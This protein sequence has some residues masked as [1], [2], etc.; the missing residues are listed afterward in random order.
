[1]SDVLRPLAFGSLVGWALDEHARHGSVFGLPAHHVHHPRGRR[2]RDAFGH[3][4]A[5]PVGAAAG[6]HTQLAQNIV[7]AYLAGARV[8]ELKTVQ[9]LDGEVIR[10]AVPK[11]CIHAEDEGQNC[12][13]STELTVR[14]ALTEYVH[15][16]L[17]IRVL[18]VEL[19]LGDGDDVVFDASVGYELDG[20]RGP[21]VD[22]FLEG[23]RD[24][25]R[26]DA[27]HLATT[28][29]EA[30]LGR[31]EHFDGQH[32]AR[33]PTRVCDSV[34]ISTMHGCP[35]AEIERI[36]EHLLGKGLHTSVKCNPTL[37][38]YDTVR[39]T[40]DRLGYAHV[41]F[42]DSHFTADLQ[43]DEAV[44]MFTRLA[45][46]AEAS[47]LVF[48]LKL[49]NTL[50]NDVTRGELPAPEMY[51]SGRALLPLTL[52]LAARL[53]RTF[54]GR[55]PIS[56][57]GG[58]D[59]STV[60]EIVRT[61]IQPVTV[62]TTL[63]KPGG[64]ARLGQLARLATPVMRD[65]HSIDPDAVDALLARV[66]AD[67]RTHKRHREKV[68]SRKTT[69]PLGLT[70]CFTAPC[71]HGGCPI[72]QQVPAYLALVAEGRIAEAFDVVARDNTAPTITGV[73]CPEPCRAHCT[74]VDYDRGIDIRGVK[75]A[76]ADAAQE[77]HV[78]ATTPTPL[79]AGVRVAVVGAGPAGIAT[80]VFLRRNGIA[81]E[82]HE[83]LDAPY[84]IVR[85]VIPTFRVTRD[86]VDR[87][88]RLAVATGVE[89][90]FGCPADY[91][92]A[93]L[94]RRFDHVVV[95]TGAWGRSPSPVRDGAG[96]VRD[97]L[98]VLREAQSR[99]GAR[100]GRRVA[101]IGA[102][103]VAMDCARTALR[104]AGVEHVALVYRRTEPFM[105]A[106]QEDVDAVRAEGIEIDE[107]LAP[108]SY[109]GSVLRCERTELADYAADGRRTTRGT[110]TFVEL[111]V[112]TV[113]GATGATVDP[114][115]YDANGIARDDLGHP[116][117]DADLRATVG[118]GTTEVYVAGDGRRGPATV[119]RAL[120][121][122]KVVARAIL[123]AHGIRFDADRPPAV[124]FTPHDVLVGRRG[125]LADRVAPPAEADRCLHC[126]EVCEVCVEVCP[127]RANVAVAVPWSAD[128]Y[129]VVHLD[130]LCNEC[131]NC[132]TFCP[133]AGLPYR[134]KPTV[135]WTLAD[136]EGSPNAGLL[137]IDDGYLVRLPSGEVVTHHR[138]R[139]DLPD[140]LERL[141]T[142]LE[143]D[144]PWLLRPVLADAG[145]GATR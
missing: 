113:I 9:V 67:P 141:L 89:F 21:V 145:G 136:F 104:A 114:D 131:G 51:L 25:T 39:G 92:L 76:A 82:V 66:L 103:D 16:H 56:Y 57:A 4:V 95:A 87:D 86:Q 2:V 105:P 85:H 112:D 47:G 71:E 106:A 111:D 143:A 63:L 62:A 38:G 108:V 59:A 61:G 32:L 91:D 139:R 11:P 28:W 37:L 140:D 52:T 115:Q 36:A 35:A 130:A 80:A 79:V 60:A 54:D 18:A 30:N 122:A 42:D 45:A 68:R 133:S 73:L 119:V 12:E 97:A 34:T 109:D 22:G 14:Q 90:R 94:R 98:E 101:V 125:V 48:G 116:R 24:A 29:L 134:D 77:Q 10:A 129:Q 83:K 46:R 69:S 49:S 8:I 5:V 96:H 107:L 93:H 15:A 137:A 55:L 128:A 132:G 6:P 74:R 144:H 75:L 58:A 121:D 99:D 102:G 20:I 1:M 120:A 135:F 142:A 64:Y 124:V 53:A 19:G 43:Y 70:D 31:F 138:G 78:A 110:G 72:G 127:N 26:T 27:W 81:V 123:R 40:L 3:L 7:T 65:F 126:D 13:W 23:L 100:L 17:A 41:A 117:L 118:D 33:V 84:G 44:A 50:P 88:Y